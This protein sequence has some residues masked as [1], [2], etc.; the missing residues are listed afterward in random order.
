VM[1]DPFNPVKI[2]TEAMKY[3]VKDYYRSW[4]TKKELTH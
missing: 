2:T 4:M 3:E 1:I